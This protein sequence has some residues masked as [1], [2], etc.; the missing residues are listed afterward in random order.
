MTE[1]N[2][3][4]S[5]SIA[6]IKNQNFKLVNCY[7]AFT[8]LKNNMNNIGFWIFLF[9]MI[10]NIIFL[11]LYCFA[12]KSFK[13]YLSKL[14]R[15][16]GY[17]WER[18]EG[19][20]FCHNYIKKLDRLIQ[21]LKEE[22]SNFLNLHG[23][24]NNPPNRRSR[25]NKKKNKKSKVVQKS[26]NS[27][28]DFLTK[29]NN[30]SKKTNKDLGKEI[31]DLK[32]RMKGTKKIKSNKIVNPKYNLMS[33]S[34][35]VK[36]NDYNIKEENDFKLNLININ[37]NEPKKNLYIP[38]N[39]DQV[40]NIYEFN[41]AIKYDKRAICTLNYIFLIYK[42]VIMYAIF[43]NSPL[44]PLPI[45]LSLLKLILGCD[46]AFNAILYT[47]D[48]VS[49]KYNSS[50]S[51]V[52]FA[53]TN[54]LLII[55]LSTLIGYIIFIALGYLINSTNEIRKL[56]R[57]EEERIKNNKSY[58]TSIQRKR[59]VILDVKNILKIRK[60]KVAFFYIIEFLLMLFF[61]YYVTVFCYIYSKT[62]MSWLLDCLITI[63]LRIIVDFLKNLIFC[64]L[65][66][67]SI[68]SN[69]KSMYKLILFIYN[70]YY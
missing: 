70:F 32:L 6:N 64:I 68:S 45:R 42:Q 20:A 43:Y 34:T 18:D 46:L 25:N 19:H 12:Q 27:T 56:F 17:I 5:E 63:V 65:Y 22:K 52:I 24:G 23:K 4:S 1:L 33:K 54:N 9:L 13:P 41:E 58:V 44:K 37:V 48:K 15:K 59:E 69:C 31:E 39:S 36:G 28:N 57:I 11:I 62:I 47:D 16:Y 51:I 40:L 66:R 8:A 7:N 55:L 26:I 30:I 21:K 3:N 2:F 49:E 29:S 38:N 61:W 67:C 10:L 60:I 14:L 50:K 35:V 53:F